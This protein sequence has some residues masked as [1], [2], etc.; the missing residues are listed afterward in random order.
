V[1]K[2]LGID[3]GTKRVGISISD[4]SQLIAT[5][6]TTIV[7]KNIFQFL[8]ELFNKQDID[9]IVIGDARN[10]DGN[11]TDSSLE[12]EKFT[13]KLKNKYPNKQISMI[14]ERFTSKIAFQS[15]IESGVKK[16]KRKDKCLIDEVSATIILQD[17]L[18]YK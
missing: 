2:A 13:T 8:N 18:S 15:I 10:L 16:Q 17:Y 5:G 3:Y 4:S 14:D 9:T 12:I 6:L 1:P 7:N 11:K